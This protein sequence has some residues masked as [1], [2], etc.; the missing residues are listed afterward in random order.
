MNTLILTAALLTAP[1]PALEDE[2]AL[3]EWCDAQVSAQNL[4]DTVVDI[5]LD[6]DF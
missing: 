1:M 6:P 2:Q 3:Y 5:C 4:T